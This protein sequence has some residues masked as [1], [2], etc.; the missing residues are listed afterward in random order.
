MKP[1]NKDNQV[2]PWRALG[3]V[4][5]IGVDIAVLLLVGLWIGKQADNYFNTSPLFLFL[6]IIIGF[7]IG[8]W[9]VV[10]LIKPF[11]GD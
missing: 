3:L 5:V 4:G 11:L 2:S 7:L 8:I 1:N 10:K 6:G 9:S